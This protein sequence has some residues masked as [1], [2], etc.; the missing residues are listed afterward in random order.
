[1][2][3]VEKVKPLVQSCQLSGIIYPQIGQALEPCIPFDAIAPHKRIAVHF[4]LKFHF[5]P[6]LCI[7]TYKTINVSELCT[8]KGA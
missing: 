8:A 5:H 3:K 7:W 4:V 2:T 6:N 1:M